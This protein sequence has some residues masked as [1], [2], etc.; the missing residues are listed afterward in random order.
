MYG[1]KL[2]LKHLKALWT[3]NSTINKPE[4][5]ALKVLQQYG[6]EYVG[7]RQFWVT[8]KDKTHKCP[9]FI[10][11][12]GRLAVEIFGD[13]WHRNDNPETLIAKYAEIGWDCLVVWEHEVY[14]TFSPEFVEN[15]LQINQIDEFKLEDFNGNWM[16]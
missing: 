15:W 4:K 16:Q 11:R 5:E 1:K 2:T 14:S 7:D 6:F 8:F 13:Y 12:S 9:D 3:I 10:H